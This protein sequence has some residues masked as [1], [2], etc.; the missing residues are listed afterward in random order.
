MAMEGNWY[1]SIS[2]ES[3]YRYNGIEHAPELGLGVYNAFY[4]TLDPAIARWWQ[5]DPEA[6]VLY[7]HSPYTAMMNSPQVYNDP[8]GDIAPLVVVGLVGAAIGGVGNLAYQACQGNINSVGPYYSPSSSALFFF[9][10]LLTTN[11]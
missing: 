10:R 5:V 2:P 1:S 4:R 6:E 8:E 7:G 9:G 11:S 3:A